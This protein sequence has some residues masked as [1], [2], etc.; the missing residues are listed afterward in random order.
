MSKTDIKL[1]CQT[2]G[3]P[4]TVPA[5][6]PHGFAMAECANGHQRGVIIRACADGTQY[7]VYRTGGRRLRYG[8]RM[9][10]RRVPE[11]VAAWLDVAGNIE[12]L[13]ELM[14]TKSGNGI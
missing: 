13:R 3:Q 8:V 11:D 5:R 6:T 12:K 4:L 10:V 7:G 9:V 1:P 2:C 14:R